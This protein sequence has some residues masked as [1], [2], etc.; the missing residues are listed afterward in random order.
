MHEYDIKLDLPNT[1]DIYL[2]YIKNDDFDYDISYL[3][4]KFIDRCGNITKIALSGLFDDEAIDFIPK[5]F[6]HF[7]PKDS[8]KFIQNEAI[9]FIESN[10]DSNE[11]IYIDYDNKKIFFKIQRHITYLVRSRE[12]SIKD[13][14][15]I[16]IDDNGNILDDCQGRGYLINFTDRLIIDFYRSLNN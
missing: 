9:N 7:T 4:P 5:F 3:P 10:A 8:F 13:N 15:Y 11:Y 12:L 2:G 6:S 1:Y 14:R 16:V